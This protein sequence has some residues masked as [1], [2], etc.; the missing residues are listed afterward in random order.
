MSLVI[1][2]VKSPFNKCQR[3]RGALKHRIQVLIRRRDTS[4]HKYLSRRRESALLSKNP[5]SL[6]R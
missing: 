2:P 5:I 3:L 4:A 1:E 6:F